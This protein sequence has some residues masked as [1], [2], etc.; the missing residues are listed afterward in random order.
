M[1]INKMT[2]SRLKNL[3]F[4][5]LFCL[6]TA[7][8][9]TAKSTANKPF[10]NCKFGAPK[11]IF[12]PQIPK[13]T[14]HTFQLNAQSAVEKVQFDGGI[15]LELIQSGCEKPKQEFQFT[16]PTSTSNF[17]DEDWL[18]MGV[19]LLGFM[20]STDPGLQPFLLWQGALKDKIG[21][22]KIGLPHQLEPGF[23]VKID[24]VAA[25]DSGLLILSLYQE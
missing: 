2:V 15:A 20:G 22:L 13:V 7:C 9:D 23:F 12:N 5:L 14:Q 25:A 21:Q 4:L 18:A 24:K 3:S 16:I 6:I 17:K 19:D 8:G 1:I 11:A 10:G